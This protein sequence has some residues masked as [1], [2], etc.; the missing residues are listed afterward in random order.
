MPASIGY[1]TVAASY[2]GRRRLLRTITN[3]YT[4]N[5]A[6]DILYDFTLIKY[7]KFGYNESEPKTVTITY[8][9]AAI[10]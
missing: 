5:I 8:I 10:K 3:R 9:I 7:N 4:L 2:T 1:Y 6:S